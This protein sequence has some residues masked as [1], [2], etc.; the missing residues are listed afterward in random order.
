MGGITAG[1]ASMKLSSS[2]V[3]SQAA[4]GGAASP[5]PLTR[6]RAAAGAGAASGAG[7][8]AGRTS[9]KATGSNT[10]SAAAAPAPL[11]AWAPG[12]GGTA[13]GSSPSPSASSTT[14]SASGKSG[15]SGTGTGTG[16]SR[17]GVGSFLRNF[18][19]SLPAQ[20][21]P[22]T[23]PS[24]IPGH[25]PGLVDLSTGTSSEGL[26]PMALRRPSGGGY[27]YSESHLDTLDTAHHQP[28]NYRHAIGSA[29]AGHG[30]SQLARAELPTYPVESKLPPP[31][32]RLRDSAPT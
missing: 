6:A 15:S 8:G 18:M 9:T 14:S 21:A 32:M 19:H 2:A 25:R 10:S 26:Y 1:L 12:T 24:S 16:G 5:G 3:S 31:Y 17:G 23:S 13:T 27:G 4:Q 28:V 11:V 22:E 29:S 7:G 20:P 30:S